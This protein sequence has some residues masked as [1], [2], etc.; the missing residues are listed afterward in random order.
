MWALIITPTTVIA[1][2]VKIQIN[3]FPAFRWTNLS[4]KEEKCSQSTVSRWAER[5]ENWGFQFRGVS[6]KRVWMINRLCLLSCKRNIL[7]D[8]DAKN[9]HITNK[10]NIYRINRTFPRERKSFN[11]IHADSRTCLCWVVTF[12]WSILVKYW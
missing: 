8:K 1:A 6:L 3:P 12:R 9:I 10:I 2:S 11:T 4:T 5:W 7:A